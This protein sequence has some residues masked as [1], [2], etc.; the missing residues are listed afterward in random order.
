MQQILL[1]A[2]ALMLPMTACAHELTPDQDHISVI[3]VGEV[4]QEPDQATLNISINAR[5]PT[6][7][8]AKKEADQR[9]SSVL[10][11]IKKAG[12]DKKQVRATRI[13]AQPE[14]EW[15]SNKRVYKGEVVSRS[16]RVTINDLDKVSPLMQALVE[17][18]VS[19]IDGMDTGFKDP[20]ALQQ[21]AL[22]AAADDAKAKAKFLA[23]RLDRNLGA[24]YKITEHNNNAPQM[25]MQDSPV[26]ARSMAAEA[27]P[28]PEM[29]GTQKVRA[30]VNVSFNLL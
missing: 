21:K 7:V 1:I 17:N 26:M 20:K 12:I 25:V 16:L 14:Y 28:P 18:G 13:N 10:E 15:R 6:L 30:T 29:F 11:V 4:E 9:Y 27:A 23:E 3:G 8:A 2:L 22:A 5:Q 19:T 24:A